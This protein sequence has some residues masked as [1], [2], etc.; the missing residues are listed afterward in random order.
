MEDG[1]C[2]VGGIKVR[3]KRRG[4]VG[5]LVGKLVGGLGK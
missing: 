2:G 4:V 5:R 1:K 3:E